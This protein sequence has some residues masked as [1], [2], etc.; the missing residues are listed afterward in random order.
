M[1]KCEI[2]DQIFYCQMLSVPIFKECGYCKLVRS[3]CFVF[4]V[5]TDVYFVQDLWGQILA[6]HCL[7]TAWVEFPHMKK[8]DGLYIHEGD[9]KT[10]WL[11]ISIQY[12][13]VRC[14][15]A[16]LQF[17]V[18]V[19]LLI[20]QVLEGEPVAEGQL[21]HLKFVDKITSKC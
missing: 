16:L 11:S 1:S 12:G 15:R 18:V 6:W 2:A 10:K 7:Y 21:Q 8:I 20:V 5:T 17:T 4:C 3:S 19:D 9:R 14:G 13:Y